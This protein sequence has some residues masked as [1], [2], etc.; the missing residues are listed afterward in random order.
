MPDLEADVARSRSKAQ[1]LYHT[2]HLKTNGRDLPVTKT[3][4][5]VT[6]DISPI[7]LIDRQLHR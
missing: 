3:Y 7:V 4:A 6:H 5:N 2:T 1:W